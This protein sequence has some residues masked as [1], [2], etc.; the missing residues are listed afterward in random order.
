MKKYQFWMMQK[1]SEFVKMNKEE[2]IA[3]MLAGSLTLDRL[4]KLKEVIEKFC[5]IE[6]ELSGSHI[7]CTFCNKLTDSWR[8]VRSH[9]IGKGVDDDSLCHEC[10]TTAMEEPDAIIEINHND[11]WNPE[12]P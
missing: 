1:M 5:E 6:A 10:Y 4:I 3:R 11:C 9:L 7:N 8:T 2:D 12:I